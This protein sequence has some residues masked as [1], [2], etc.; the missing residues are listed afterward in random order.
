MEHNEEMKL[1]TQE[2]KDAISEVIIEM[3]TQSFRSFF[4][5]TR[6]RLK[7]FHQITNN[8]WIHP[9]SSLLSLE[10]YLIS[11]LYPYQLS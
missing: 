2:V 8:S 10:I 5:N 9:K 7:T 1:S 6:Q 11:F 3:K 4:T